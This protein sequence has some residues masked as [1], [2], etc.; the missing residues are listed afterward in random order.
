M[1]RGRVQH[2]SECRAKGEAM[3]EG[4]RMSQRGG[5][6]KEEGG[7]GG[8]RMDDEWQQCLTRGG[9]KQE[10]MRRSERVADLGVGIGPTERNL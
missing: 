2:V 5:R 1:R 3:G 4:T 7:R 9:L 8:G 6:R 10:T